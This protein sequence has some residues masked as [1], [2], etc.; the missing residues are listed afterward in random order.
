M[1]D[2]AAV[3]GALPPAGDGQVLVTSQSAL[4][5]PG[6]VLDVPVL[7]TET[8]A[9]FLVNRTGAAGQEAAARELAA[10][11]G[12]LPLALEQAAAYM[13]ATGRSMA[14]YLEL[15]RQ[16]SMEL[17]ARGEVAGYGKQ[18]TT[19]W[20]LAFDQIGQAAPQAAG[21]LRL[22][23]CCAPEA[24][25]LGLLL[26]PQ[27]EDA[28]PFGPEVGRLLGPLLDD[29]VTVDDAVAVL[30][31]YSLIS[32]PQRLGVGAPAGPGCHPRPAACGAGRVVAAG[33]RR[34]DRR[35]AAP[36]PAA[37]TAW[38]QY[39]ALLPHAEAALTLDSIGMSQIA[40]YLGH[41]GSY[42]A[43]RDLYRQVVAAHVQAHGAE[44][45]NPAHPR[46]LA[47]WTGEAGDPAGARDL[48]A[49]LQPVEERVLGP[50]H[51]ETLLAR[52]NLA[53]WTGEAGDR[54]GRGISSPRCCPLRSG[55]LALST[56]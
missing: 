8:A 44:H 1:T 43:A 23:A 53:R 46:H 12:G 9:G 7:D 39:T 33:R 38:P 52:A 17:L 2:L 32:A 54:S 31:R 5:P 29:P 11:L 6:Q 50:E 56:P 16:R 13:Q 10:E 36:R 18:V 55:C 47:Y 28:A 49:A 41:R 27:P 42:V 35:R 14:S 4:W 19:T 24:I 30:R 34:P 15:F 22:L 48:Y 45:P 21:L 20:A 37:A 25:P 26:H 3:Q 40:R 51:S